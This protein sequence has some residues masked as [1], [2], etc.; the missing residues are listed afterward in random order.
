MEDFYETGI[1]IWTAFGPT[2]SIEKKGSR[3]II[4]NFCGLFFSCFQGQK[5]VKIFLKTL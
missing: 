2:G 4:N 1:E 3:T 5:N